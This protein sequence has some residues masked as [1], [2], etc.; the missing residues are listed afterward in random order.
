MVDTTNNLE[1]EDY[2]DMSPVSPLLQTEL[3]QN[4]LVIKII[5]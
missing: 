4:N 3:K 2:S 1:T 5:N